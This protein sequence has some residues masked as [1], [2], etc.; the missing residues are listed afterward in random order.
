MEAITYDDAIKVLKSYAN[1]LLDKNIPG[2]QTMV[3]ILLIVS[4][5]LEDRR[6]E[7]NKEN[8]K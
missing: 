2:T 6:E 5:L 4:K 7:I 1:D 8:N 3:D